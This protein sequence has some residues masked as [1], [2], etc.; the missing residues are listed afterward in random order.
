ML[1][2][3]CCMQARLTAVQGHGG[4]CGCG[5]LSRHVQCKAADL[6]G[7]CLSPTAA[8]QLTML[9]ACAFWK[10]IGM[11]C[12]IWLQAVHNRAL[13]CLGPRAEVSGGTPAT[14]RAR[15]RT[16]CS[17]PAGRLML[18]SSC[19]FHTMAACYKLIQPYTHWDSLQ[20][21]EGTLSTDMRWKAVSKCC[22]NHT[23]DLNS[24]CLC[25]HCAGCLAVAGGHRGGGG[26]EPAAGPGAGRAE[27]AQGAAVGQR[28]PHR[29]A[30]EVRISSITR[31][32]LPTLTLFASH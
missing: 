24:K 30:R 8:S 22:F 6:L 1:S 32:L 31:H 15:Q 25:Q 20:I 4:V 27:R 10:Q 14:W 28:R 21:S 29:G 9:A 16:C 5:R 2:D 12:A 13:H 19:T 18:V 3:L 7:S 26:A 23:R 17:R 11:T